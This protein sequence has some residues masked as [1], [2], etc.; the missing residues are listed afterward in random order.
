M[1]NTARKREKRGR[2]GKRKNEGEQNKKQVSK[3][4]RGRRG[5]E[6]K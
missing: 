3:R 1:R 5:Q 2:G 6:R 4:E